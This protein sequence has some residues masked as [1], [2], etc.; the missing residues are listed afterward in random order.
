MNKNL[1]RECAQ[2]RW[3]QYV[4]ARANA[5]EQIQFHPWDSLPKVVKDAEIAAM[6]AVLGHVALH[7][8]T[9]H[10]NEV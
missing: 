10:Y 7:A 2:M 4:I 8:L 1:I 5:P 3:D 6:A 9:G